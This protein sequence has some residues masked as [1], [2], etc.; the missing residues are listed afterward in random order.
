MISI[1]IISINMACIGW[2]FIGSVKMGPG[3][4][5][6]VKAL[7]CAGPL[8]VP[9]S[10]ALT[11]DYNGSVYNG[12]QKWRREGWGQKPHNEWSMF[13]NVDG[14]EWNTPGPLLTKKTKVLSN[15]CKIK[16]LKN[17]YHSLTTTW[18]PSTRTGLAMVTKL[19]CVTMKKWCTSVTYQG[20][21]LRLK[22]GC[23]FTPMF[24]AIPVHSHWTHWPLG[25][26]NEILYTIES[27]I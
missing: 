17:M 1:H 12:H 10:S 3:C 11:G 22:W 26:L 5:T 19:P 23:L 27:L 2:V 18:K 7:T 20:C 9:G 16:G 21:D 8:A 24:G 25:E 4:T 13:H 6:R 14:L 15:I